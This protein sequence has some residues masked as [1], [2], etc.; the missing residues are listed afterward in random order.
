MIN[1]DRNYLNNKSHA[2]YNV[3][4]LIKRIINFFIR[5]IYH[6]CKNKD[7]DACHDAH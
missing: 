4:R 7:A 3:L 5:M 6:I 2:I 1:G